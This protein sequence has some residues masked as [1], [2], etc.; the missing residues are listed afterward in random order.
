LEPEKNASGF[1]NRRFPLPVPANKKIEPRRK[2]DPE[3][4]EAA[5]IAELQ[6]SEHLII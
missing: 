3:G 5:K 1:K 2:F 6:I 4:I